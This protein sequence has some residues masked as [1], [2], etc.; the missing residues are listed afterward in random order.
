[1]LRHALRVDF[2]DVDEMVNKV[3]GLL[4]YPELWGELSDSG[5][6]EVQDPRVGLDEAARRTADAYRKTVAIA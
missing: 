2:W 3:V 5:L 6:A 1:V 4:R